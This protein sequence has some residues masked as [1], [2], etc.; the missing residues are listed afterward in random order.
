MLV[1]SFGDVVVTND[2]VT[3]LEEMDIEHPSA[4]MV[5]D[6]ADSQEEETGDGTTSAVVIA[7]GGGGEEEEMPDVGGPPGGGM[8]GG[9]MP[10]G[11]GGL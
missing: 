4:E 7:G 3:I 5:V 8:P 10:G 1:T 6:V 11:M 9:G 2:G